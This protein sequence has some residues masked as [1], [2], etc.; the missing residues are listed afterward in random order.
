MWRDHNIF[1]MN[2]IPAVTTGMP[3]WRP[4]SQDL[5]RSALIYALTALAVCGRADD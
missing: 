2:R 1:N 4:T 5:S 3:R